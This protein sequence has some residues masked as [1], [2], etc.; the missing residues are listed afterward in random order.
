MKTKNI[1]TKEIVLDKQQTSNSKKMNDLK[2]EI[3]NDKNEKPVSKKEKENNSFD[4]EMNDDDNYLNK[5]KNSFESISK[6]MFEIKNLINDITNEHKQLQKNIQK[7]LKSIE[8]KKNKVILKKNKREPSGFAK[9]TK[10]SDDLCDFLGKPFGTEMARTEVTKFLTSY[11]KMNN[12]Q[13]TE[14]KRK[15]K[16]DTKLLK[17]LNVDINEEV[18][19]FNLQKWMKPHFPK[20]ELEISN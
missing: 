15:I 2:Q 14:D 11:I 18:T 7:D 19:Y 4:L 20:T 5:Y 12:L 3:M 17:L 9:P 6:K 16:P 1:K 13:Q 10:L 8:K